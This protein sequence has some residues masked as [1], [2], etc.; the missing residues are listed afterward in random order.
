MNRCKTEYT[1]YCIVYT[2]N[3]NNNFIVQY[4]LG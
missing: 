3:N 1:L 2:V 4:G